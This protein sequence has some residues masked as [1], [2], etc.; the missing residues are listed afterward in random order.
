MM[1]KAA[2][3]QQQSARLLLLTKR[4][5]LVARASPA[6]FGI[7]QRQHLLDARRSLS[8]ATASTT[9]DETATAGSLPSPPRTTSLGL[10]DALVQPHVANIT[11]LPEVAA[12][13]GATSSAAKTTLE[14]LRRAT[15]IF[16]SFQPGGAEHVAVLALQAEVLQVQ[17][18]N[19]HGAYTVLQE[20]Q[21]YM[22]DNHNV[23][24]AVCKTLWLQGKVEA[25][26]EQTR[27]LQQ[28]KANGNNDNDPLLTAAVDCAHVLAVLLHEGRAAAHRAALHVDTVGL[29]VTAQALQYLNI[30]IVEAVW[31]LGHDC[32]GDNTCATQLEIAKETWQQ[33]LTLLKEKPSSSSGSSSSDQD[34][35]ELSLRYA[36]EGRLQSNL[37]Y[38]VLEMA[39]RQEAQISKASEHAREALRAFEHV[40]AVNDSGLADEGWTRALSLVAQCYHR[41][42]H[43]VTAEGLLQSALDDTHASANAFNALSPLCLLERQAAYQA[44]AALCKDWEK[45]KGDADRLLAQRR[46]LTEKLPGAWR[47]ATELYSALWFWTPGLFQK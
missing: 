14:S 24:L 29:P 11:Q 5:A 16:A 46:A 4:T 2:I 13:L 40:R 17:L 44:Y 41:A 9:A 45:R 18:A 22:D 33:G 42:G 7:H 32:A 43:A 26:M 12:A 3:A 31:G 21:K 34:Q 36:L 27:A 15:D 1:M 35:I 38:A 23:A 28:Q 30:G 39:G 20:M 8:T 47:S 6:V 25:C 37:A 19:Y 10:H